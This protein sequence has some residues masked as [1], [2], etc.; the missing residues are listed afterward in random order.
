[1]PSAMAALTR[2]DD[3]VVDGHGGAEEPRLA[4]RQVEAPRRARRRAPDHADHVLHHQDHGEGEQELERLVPVVH[5]AEQPALHDRPGEP[6][7]ETGDG[8]RHDE[9]PGRPAGAGVPRHRRHARVGA[10]RVE[11][12]AGEVEDPLDPEDHLES[13]R[14]EE[15]DGG[16]EDAAQQDADG[17]R[18]QIFQLSIQGRSLAPAGFMAVLVDTTSIGSMVTKS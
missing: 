13:R 5:E 3:Q 7:E 18:D 10:Q 2:D 17:A 11:R 16:V 14:H 1:M 4:V 15:Q 9:Q 8:Q 12:A 6:D